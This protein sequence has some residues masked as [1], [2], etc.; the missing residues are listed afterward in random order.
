MKDQEQAISYL[1]SDLLLHMDMLESIRRGRA[2][3]LYVDQDGVLLLDQP[4]GTYMVSASREAAAEKMLPL[5][6]N[7]ELIECHQKFYA[8]ELAEQSRLYIGPDCYQAVYCKEQWI[9]L[10]QTGIKIKQLDNTF[11]SAV[12]AQYHMIQEDQYLLGRLESGVMYG[13]FLEKEL[14]GFIGIHEEGSIGLLEV[15]PEYRRRGIGMALEAHMVNMMLDKGWTPFGQIIEGNAASFSLQKSLGFSI[16][17]QPL[18]WMTSRP[19]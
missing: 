1:E 8:K 2:A 3:L 11:L 4:S 12:K 5:I 13:A 6:K 17:E 15:L 16:A 18:F 7:A 14:A 10:E 19:E 9:S